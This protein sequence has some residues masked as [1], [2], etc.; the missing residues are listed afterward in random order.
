ML[1]YHTGIPIL[2]TYWLLNCHQLLSSLFITISNM[3]SNSISTVVRISEEVEI[4][5]TRSIPVGVDL[6]EVPTLVFLHYWGGSAGTWASVIKGLSPYFPTVA[7]SLRGWGAS[8]G[9]ADS[10]AYGVSDFSADVEAVIKELG[11]SNV[12]LVGHSMGGKVAM[13]IAGRSLL[14]SGIIKA[15]ALIAPAPPTP[16]ILPDPSMRDTQVHAFDNMTNARG[17]IQDVLTVKGNPALTED[18]IDAVAADM[19]RGNQFAK[20][21]WPDYGAKEDIRELFARITVP[22]LV[23][24]GEG[25]II[26]PPEKMRTEIRDELNARKNGQAK[27]IVVAG[28]G[29]LLPVEKPDDVASAVKTFVQDL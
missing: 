24:V 14:P 1:A 16:F 25:D 26:E 11:L 17:V 23:V 2:R 18:V 9:P 27:L 6:T 22:V 10:S 13:A 3:S 5:L 8:P 20:S 12:V 7:L 29:H 21:S 15:L 4:H 19:V 28:S